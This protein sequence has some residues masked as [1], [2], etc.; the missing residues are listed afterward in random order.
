MEKERKIKVL[1]LVALI[2]AILGLTVAFAALSQ[3]LT[4]NGTANI[5]AASWDI[6][7]NSDIEIF[8]EGAAKVNG[9]PTVNN[10][11]M[12]NIN[13]IITKPNDSI[14]IDA[15]IENKGTINA[16]VSS[17]EI[18]KL[19]TL[20]S[21]VESCDWNDDGTIT[22]EDIDKVNENISFFVEYYDTNTLIKEDD[23]LNAG[24]NKKITLIMGYLK[25]SN[26]QNCE[27]ST[28]LPKRNLTFNDL[29]VKVNY[30]QAD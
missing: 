24:E 2:V 1:S 5:D 17:V 21:P 15:V 28:E 26:S 9:Q 13:I 27:E 20:T 18:S 14:E 10:A 29:R 7:F 22:Q 8:E 16:K 12:N 3:T 25:C 11:S 23:V 30:V 19:C 6:G 4:I